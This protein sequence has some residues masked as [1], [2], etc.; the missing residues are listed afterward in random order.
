MKIL[1]LKNENCV[2]EREAEAKEGERNPQHN[3]HHNSQHS[4]TDRSFWLSAMTYE[5]SYSGTPEQVNDDEFVLQMM[6]FVFK[7]M[8]FVFKMMN[9]AFTMMNLALHMMIMYLK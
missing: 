5:G 9:L 6:V 3:P 1:L 8:D 7:M 4:L 2:D